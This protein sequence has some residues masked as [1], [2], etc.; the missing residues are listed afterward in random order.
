MPGSDRDKLGKVTRFGADAVV[1][2]LEDAVASDQKTAARALA[3]ET[4]GSFQPGGVVMVRV[5]GRQTGR[6][7]EDIRAVVAPGL[8]AIVVPKVEDPETLAEADRML[9]EFE[10]DAGIEPGATRLLAI[11]ETAK[12]VAR[13]EHVLAEAPQRL[14]TTIFGSGD[15]TADLGIDLVEDPQPLLYARSRLVVATRAA[16]LGR[17]IDGPWLR[18]SDTEGL[19]RDSMRSRGLGFQGRVTVYPP[20]VDP[21][22]RAYSWVP[23][24]EVERANRVVEAFAEA[25]RSGVAS[26]RVDGGFVDY[27]IYHRALEKLRLHQ[28]Y[29]ETIG[30]RR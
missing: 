5:N 12:G 25:E 13:C 27:P 29:R 23:E 24:K 21:I 17:P 8:H 10:A 1:I 28:A 20:Q 4:L 22:Q 9:A 14:L 7:A 30:S 16:G 3:R 11:V 2:D 6:M 26:I 15:L 19:E 18:L